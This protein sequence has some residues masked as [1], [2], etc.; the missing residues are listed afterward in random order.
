MSV[1]T[2]PS[3]VETGTADPASI[4]VVER[5]RRLVP[6]L[7]E[8]APEFDEADRFVAANYALLTEAGLVDAGVPRELGGSGAE[9]RELAEMLRVLA[10]GCGATALAFS[11]HTHQVAVPAW[12]WRHQ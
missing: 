1:A 12:R 3:P 10:H 9:V 4:S 11:M 7:A 2:A 6:T 8:R 5:A